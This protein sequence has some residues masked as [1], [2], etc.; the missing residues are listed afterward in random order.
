MKRSLGQRGLLFVCLVAVHGPDTHIFT[1]IPFFFFSSGG[2]ACVRLHNL[3]WQRSLNVGIL[4][5]VSA[6]FSEPRLTLQQMVSWN[7]MFPER[8]AL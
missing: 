2:V 8:A 4:C 7:Q 1:L 6:L 3:N 5:F